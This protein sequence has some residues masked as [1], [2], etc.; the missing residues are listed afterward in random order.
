MKK[1]GFLYRL[2][3][4]MYE[5]EIFFSDGLRKTRHYKYNVQHI[6]VLKPTHFKAIDENGSLIELRT[7]NPFDYNLKKLY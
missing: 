4:D 7:Q 3:N 2:F 1:R 6:K 5:V